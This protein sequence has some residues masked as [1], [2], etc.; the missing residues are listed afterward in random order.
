MKKQGNAE[1][2]ARIDSLMQSLESETLTKEQMNECYR[3][4]DL[5]KKEYD[6][7]DIAFE[8][9]GKSGIKDI[10]G[11]I[12]VPAMYKEFPALFSYH[13]HRNG[14]IAAMDFNDK[15]A[16]VA[17]DG[18]GAPLCDFK[19][20][21]IYYMFGTDNFFVCLDGEGDNVAGGVLNAKG[22]LIVP[23]KMDTI[24]EFANNYAAVEKNGKFGLLAYDGTFIEPIYDDVEDEEGVIKVCKDGKWGYLSRDLDFIAEEEWERME[25]IEL[26]D[27]ITFPC[28]RQKD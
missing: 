10:S 28:S 24:Y 2:A 26:L 19:Y 15:Y 22:E 27:L 7:F 16:I 25:N 8:E 11:R 13:C 1:I 21:Y 17:T 23:C 18:T 20:D 9:S 12:R 6:L 14:P 3:E 4:L 5:I